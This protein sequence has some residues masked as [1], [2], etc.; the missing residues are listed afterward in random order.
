MT[1]IGWAIMALV[2]GCAMPQAGAA[3][4]AETARIRV[5]TVGLPLYMDQ[6][7][8]QEVIVQITGLDPNP[9]VELDSLRRALT[10][11]LNADAM[12]R[13]DGIEAQDG[14]VAV[15]AL[16]AAEIDIVY[17][18][19]ALR[20][21]YT[22]VVDATASRSIS[23]RNRPQ[24]A[25][26]APNA[27]PAKLSGFVNMRHAA[28]LRH[29]DGELTLRTGLDGAVRVGPVV[30][31]GSGAVDTETGFRR[32]ETRAVYDMPA[33]SSRI[34][35]G[36]ILVERTG[37][38]SGGAL[39]GILFAKT[40]ASDQQSGLS[41]SG[42]GRT[43]RLERRSTVEIFVND[44]L[45]RRAVLDAGDY[46]ID[47]LALTTSRNTVRIRA[48]DA[49]GRVTEESFSVFFDSTLLAVGETDYAVSLGV[50]AQPTDRDRTYDTDRVVGSAF[51]R[52]GMSDR[53]TLGANGQF[54]R[55]GAMIGGDI[56]TTL[57]FAAVAIDVAA[58]H[59]RDAGQ[60]YAIDIELSFDGKSGGGV[61]GHADQINFSLTHTS[62]NFFRVG[63]GPTPSN[64]VTVST[65]IAYSRELSQRTGF[66]LSGGY[67][68]LRDGGDR[69][70]A[71]LGMYHRLGP[72]VSLRGGMG[73]ASGEDVFG[74]LGLT[75][76]FSPDG[77]ALA[78]YDTR[79]NTFDTG[80]SYSQGD[81]V[82]AFNA[83][84]SIRHS[85]DGAAISG[86]LEYVGNRYTASLSHD[87][88][89]D[90]LTKIMD[91]QATTARLGTAIAFADGAFAIG[92]P[93]GSSFAILD[94]HPSLDGSAVFIRDLDERRRATA[95]G[96]GP[97]VY[98][99]SD[100]YQ[101]NPIAYDVEP[102][103]I[104][105]AD[106]EGIFRIKP[107]YR[108]GYRLT[109]GSDYHITAIG[110]A[111]DA[112][113]DPIGNL[114]GIARENGDEQGQ[115]VDL[116]T[117]ASGRFAAQGM[118]PGMWE[119]VLPTIPETRLQIEIPE[120]DKAFIRLGEVRP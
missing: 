54:D 43:F 95:D 103:P 34:S 12:A 82:G 13:F 73:Y 72:D 76:R 23:L 11:V 37:F 94:T 99:M 83:G 120:T 26:L 19:A 85:D 77:V 60:G 78:N 50:E 66:S 44:R 25:P 1:R 69:A 75:Y 98:P 6:T 96:F 100:S 117:N 17:D 9:S 27:F 58:S 15:E 55:D 47:D 22:P 88:S 35:A 110:R 36:D 38:Q 90:A 42:E 113:G 111:L 4:K 28:Q 3:P 84:A 32:F 51:Y 68:F 80:I 2:L 101:T 48:E 31:E 63:Q 108:T 116:F 10:P 61:T 20:L 41:G 87:S 49:D 119:V 8:L 52:R 64:P 104:G 45:R 24:Q 71:Q 106:D 7:P 97:A 114:I 79:N 105:Y 112:A 21:I 56:L 40:L 74:F 67:D 92:R 115:T 93:I 14:F 86:D 16:G 46:T 118:R 59:S 107:G 91:T 109:V 57:P 5:M 65:N 29:D 102:R 53:L 18:A 62:E 89:G 81:Y 30:L 70:F 33:L 39:G